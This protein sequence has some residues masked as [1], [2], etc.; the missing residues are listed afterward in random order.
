MADY[1]KVILPGQEGK[2]GITI[3]GSK[4]RSGRFKKSFTVKTNDP[5][6]AKVILYVT[7][8]VKKVLKLSHSLSVS[9]FTNELLKVET[10]I[11]NEL[12]NPVNIKSWHWSEESK[13]DY[14]LLCRMIGVK[15]EGIESGR[16]YR[17]KTWTREELPPGRYIGD[18]ILETDFKEL[19]E[20]K[21]AFSITITPDVQV[22]PKRI[23]MREMRV[24]EG[25]TKNF[26]KTVSIVAARGDSL[27]VLDIIP[28]REDMTVKIR[29]V[30]EGKS[31]SC[32]IS[33]RP[34]SETGSY[35]GSI[36]FVTN[37]PGYEKI[38]TPIKG[39]VRVMKDQK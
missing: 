4:I 6:N 34:P 15:L 24:P 22:H 9:G 29:E 7:A 10:I 1:D 8:V 14:D 5:E 18:I 27:K 38:V 19:P 3:R 37:Y 12:D 16:K 23:I 36:T 20:K 25:R 33:I 26:E 30:R 28:S 13:K 2:I 32:T 35:N 17:L 21:V 39:M 11:T 31:F